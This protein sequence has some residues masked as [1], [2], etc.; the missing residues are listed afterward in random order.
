MTQHT[1][2]A[3]AAARDHR[4]DFWRG[5]ALAMIFVNHIP[6]TVWEN[7]TSRNFGFSDSAELFVFLAGFASA[8]AYARLFLAGN[9]LVATLKAWR[10]AGV[11]YLVHVTLTAIA[12]ALFV[13]AALA[14]GKGAL[15][16]RIGLTSLVQMP[17]ETLIG[18]PTL[19][20]QF[21]Y[22]NILPMYSV[23]L[24]LLPIHL[25]LASIDRQLMLAASVVMWVLAFAFSIDMP[26]YPLPGGWFFNPFAWQLI[27]S[28]GLYCGLSRIENGIAV[29]YRPWLFRLCLGYA[30]VSFLTVE[31]G[32]WGPWGDLPFPIL[33]SGF[34]K[35]YVSLPRLL[36]LLALCYLFANAA[37]SSPFARIARGNPFA[38]LGRHSLP[39]FAFGTTLS[40][41]AQVF[42]AGR[43]DAI[44]ADTLIIVAGLALQFALARYLD[45][46]RT[47]SKVSLRSGEPVPTP[48]SSPPVT[49]RVPARAVAL[50]MATAPGE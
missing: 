43:P 29:A 5:V 45:W 27:F 49:Q 38:M 33:I 17:L 11:L 1:K 31:Y 14:L 32:L 34:D 19:G 3:A 44:L 25:W 26:N 15:L 7:F 18:F 10:R 46:W 30:F 41:C 24:I 21:G 8:Y 28:I 39:V 13:W 22:V 16:D 23:I 35:T 6:G 12:V 20:H 42:K 9:R 40:L 4:V 36:H 37:P 50:S 48:A 2:L 47:A